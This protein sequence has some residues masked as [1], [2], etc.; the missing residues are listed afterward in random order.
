MKTYFVLDGDNG[1]K[2]VNLREGRYCSLKR[3]SGIKVDEEIEPQPSDENLVMMARYYTTLKRLELSSNKKSSYTIV[4][5]I[6]KY[7]EEIE[8]HGNPKHQDT[9]YTRT[10]FTWDPCLS[11]ET[12]IL[13]IITISSQP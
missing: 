2:F 8:P 7:R 6:G 10:P 1:L 3:Q 4:E 11:T 9:M 5:Y 12:Q 13:K